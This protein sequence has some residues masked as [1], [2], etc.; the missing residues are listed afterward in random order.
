M[1]LLI[2]RTEFRHESE[3]RLLFQYCSE[4]SVKQRPERFWP[5]EFAPLATLEEPTLD[6]RLDDKE[7]TIL[8]RKIESYGFCG[9]IERSPLYRIP[10][11]QVNLSI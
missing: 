2:K 3:V 5:F 8:G 7:T 9:P 4:D 11:F 10:N 6:P 1:P